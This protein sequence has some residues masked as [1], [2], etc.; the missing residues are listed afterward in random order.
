[1]SITYSTPSLH[2]LPHFAPFVAEKHIRQIFSPPILY[3]AFSTFHTLCQLINII[4]M[5]ISMFF[6]VLYCLD[7]TNSS[8]E[9]IFATHSSKRLYFSKFIVL[10]CSF[11]FPIRIIMLCLRLKLLQI[12]NL[13]IRIKLGNSNPIKTIHIALVVTL[14]IPFHN[15]CIP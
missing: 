9:N 14:K 2:F 15:S 5:S 10:Q 1:M 6:S 3:N 13:H 4:Q 8:S 12:T 7:T 11:S